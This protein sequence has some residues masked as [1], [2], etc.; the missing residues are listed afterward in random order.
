MGS[1]QEVTE[2]PSVFSLQQSL[3]AVVGPRT[4]PQP[5]QQPRA[6]PAQQFNP[7]Q[8]SSQPST[9]IKPFVHHLPSPP[10]A[11]PTQAAATQSVPASQPQFNSFN[12][13]NTNNFAAFDAQFGGAAPINN[14]VTQLSSNIFAQP[15][16]RLLQGNDVIVNAPSVFG[17][18]GQTNFQSGAFTQG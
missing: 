10:A 16:S 11:A 8:F 1:L 9:Q 3:G 2:V 5:Q 18:F 4:A 12:L 6:F 17:G 13:L 7:Q 15:G 14:G